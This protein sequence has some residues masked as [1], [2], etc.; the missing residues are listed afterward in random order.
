[1]HNLCGRDNI[2]QMWVVARGTVGKRLRYKHLTAT[3]TCLW[4]RDTEERPAPRIA[5][6]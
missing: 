5:L 3:T 2:H 6:S 4:G 1:M